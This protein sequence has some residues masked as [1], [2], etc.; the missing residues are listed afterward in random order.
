MSNEHIL[1]NK[2]TTQWLGIWLDSQL[3]FT[4]HI[5]KQVRKAC[6]L[7]LQIKGLTRIYGLVLELVQRIQAAVV[8]STALYGAEL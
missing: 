5:N 4:S 7:E 3:N 8:Q 2:E 6:T 1:F